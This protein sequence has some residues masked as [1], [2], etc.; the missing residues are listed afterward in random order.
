MIVMEVMIDQEDT[1]D[2][3][4]GSAQVWGRK[5]YQILG[6]GSMS[7]LPQVVIRLGYTTGLKNYDIY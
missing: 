6:V 4:I 5:W 2:G 1:K 3:V 7:S